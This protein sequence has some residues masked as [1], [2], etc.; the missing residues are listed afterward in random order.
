MDHSH[1]RHQDNPPQQD[2]DFSWLLDLDF[3]PPPTAVIPEFRLSQP[4]DAWLSPSNSTQA[5]TLHSDV[6]DSHITGL[7]VNHT[8][9]VETLRG[10]TAHYPFLGYMSLRQQ[11]WPLFVSIKSVLFPKRCTGCYY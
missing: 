8:G 1:D 7:I 5:W 4:G 3:I 11:L 10:E 9:M 2:I 6:Q